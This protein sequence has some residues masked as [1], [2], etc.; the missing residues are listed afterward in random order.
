MPTDDT[1]APAAPPPEPFRFSPPATAGAGWLVCRRVRRS[2][3][4]DLCEAI[5]ASLDHLRPWMPW[6]GEYDHDK[7]E[8]F[9]ARHTRV[10]GGE[11]VEDAPYVV[12]DLAGQLLG[13]CGLHARLG[14]GA[15]EIGYWVDVRHTRRGVATLASALLT[16]VALALPGVG[17]V[18]IH[19]DQANVAS[20]AVPA[21]LGYTHVETAP[22]EPQAPS[23]TGINW[24]WVMR[25]DDFP[26]SPAAH[27][28]TT[29]RTT[30]TPT[31]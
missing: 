9:T 29:A 28:L 11:P 15:L 17:S 14:P 31:P 18:E 3:T 6:A 13:L 21:R 5:L 7:A 24:R 20:G 22:D 23:D 27:L 26:P 16:D 4:D 10:A 1:S 8:E 2:D 30:P 19:H 25:R 12:R